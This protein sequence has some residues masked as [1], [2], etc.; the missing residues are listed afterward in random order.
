MTLLSLP[1]LGLLGLSALVIFLYFLR[2]R[3]Q[4]QTVSALFLWRA[5]SERPRSALSLLWAKLGLLLIQ[6]LALALIV[7]SLARPVVTSAALGGGKIAVIVDGSASM[8][9]R[10]GSETRYNEALS[11][12]ERYIKNSR[13]S[14]LTILQAQNESRLLVP[15]TENIDD[16][17]EKLK[18]SKPTLESD[19][20]ARDL[21]EILRSQGDLKEY[22]EVAF[23]TD[24]IPSNPVW[25]GLP[26]RLVALG[27]SV[28]NIAVTGFGVRLEPNRNLGYSVWTEITNYSEAPAN[29]QL[30]VQAD[31][32]I[33]HS[34]TLTIG[35][36]K[37]TVHSFEYSDFSKTR[38]VAQVNLLNGQDAF[39]YDNQRFFALAER[40]TLNVLWVG[41]ANTF[42]ERALLANARIRIARKDKLSAGDDTSGADLI[43]ANN[44]KLPLISQG[45]W[46]IFNSSVDPLIETQ[47]AEP[48]QKLSVFQSDHPLL[49]LIEPNH[50]RIA[51]VLRSI[52][53]KEGKMILA[54]GDNP[55]VYALEMPQLKLVGFGFSLQESNLVLTVDF[56]ILMKNALGWLFPQL[57]PPVPRQVGQALSLAGLAHEGLQIYR[58]NG[59]LLTVGENQSFV[60]TDSPGFY[61]VHSNQA[62]RY[63]AVNLAAGES[64]PGAEAVQEPLVKSQESETQV[65]AQ[66]PLWKYLLIFALFALCGELFVY[67]RSLFRPTAGGTA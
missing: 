62:V 9:T 15:L 5:S 20:N 64:E 16:A 50:I 35:S 36:N 8:Q 57:E 60:E 19:A 18:N 29:L 17:L 10:Y 67:D 34:V 45:R 7:L 54:S 6:L 4:S 28:Q 59:G 43:I 12:A 30:R 55:A 47:T 61:R 42:L 41:D 27:R 44:A 66:L 2:R 39:P 22:R 53:P 3:A 31:D 14:Q 49:R 38:F 58:P 11:Q 21:I 26:A 33:I 56:P 24:R 52:L 37:N 65:Q 46:L 23:F 25:K 32:Q 63:W 13:P 40:T 51:K 1:M 48:A